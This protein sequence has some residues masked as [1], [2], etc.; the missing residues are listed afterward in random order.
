MYFLDLTAGAHMQI[1]D[2][3]GVSHNQ[4]DARRK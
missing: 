3:T 1:D 2:V 4:C